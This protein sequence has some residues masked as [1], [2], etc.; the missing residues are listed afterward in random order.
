MIVWH[1]TPYGTVLAAL[2]WLP[3][4]RYVESFA[5]YRLAWSFEQFATGG[6]AGDF[7]GWLPAFARPHRPADRRSTQAFFT[8]TV[9]ADVDLAFD[10]G[11]LSQA[12][13]AALGPKRLRDSGAFAKDRETDTTI[14]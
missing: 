14:H 9:A 2:E 11:F 4:A 3:T 13:L 1:E 8:P 12:A 10:L 6:K 7:M 5:Q